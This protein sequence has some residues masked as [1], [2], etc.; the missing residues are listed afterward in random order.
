MT[1]AQFMPDRSRNHNY[2]LP[3]TDRTRPGPRSAS[4]TATLVCIGYGLLR[5]VWRGPHQFRSPKEF[6]FSHNAWVDSDGVKSNVHFGMIGVSR[7]PLPIWSLASLRRWKN[8]KGTWCTR[9]IFLP[10][11]V[12][13]RRRRTHKARPPKRAR[14]PGA[15]MAPEST[16]HMISWAAW[17][18]DRMRFVHFGG[19]HPPTS[20]PESLGQVG[21]KFSWRPKYINLPMM[22]FA[23]TLGYF[24]NQILNNRKAP[25]HAHLRTDMM[26]FIVRVF[27]SESGFEIFRINFVS[28]PFKGRKMVYTL[29][30]ADATSDARGDRGRSRYRFSTE[31]AYL[32]SISW[33]TLNLLTRWDNPK[34]PNDHSM[35]VPRQNQQ[36][37]GW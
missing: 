26:I 36:Q 24:V 28:R 27:L 12:K 21:R 15:A 32:N 20:S 10:R 11:M 3:G 7:K 19:S 31:K 2:P 35:D 14:V 18:Y 4:L 13:Y 30:Q 8:A 34:T 25:D 33:M 17:R 23:F 16:T 9:P 29:G 5:P 6:D 22:T 37:K 1:L